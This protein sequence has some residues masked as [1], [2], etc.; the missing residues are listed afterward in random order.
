[1]PE[2]R[3]LPTASLALHPEAAKVP[4][5]P[6][7]QYERFLADVKVRGIREPIELIPHTKIVIEGRTRLR[8]ATDAG[9]AAVPVKD[10]DLADDTP[11]VYMLRAALLRR[12]LTKDQAAML[13]VEL[14]KQFAEEA[15]QR[16]L[17]GAKK[18]GETAGRGRA[19]D[20]ADS[21]VANSPQ[22]NPDPKPAASPKPERAPTSR[23]RAAELAD[24]G[25]RKVSD[26][27]LVTT[28]APEL[29]AKVSAG[30]MKLAAAVKEVKEKEQ[31]KPVTPKEPK[32]AK[33]DNPLAS[34]CQL[35]ELQPCP[36]CGSKNVG[37]TGLE[38]Y[39]YCYDCKA[40]GPTPKDPGRINSTAAWNK[41]AKLK[42]T[43]KPADAPVAATTC[44]KCKATFDS[45]KKKCPSCNWVQPTEAAKPEPSTAAAIS[46]N[47]IT[48]FP[49]DILKKL[50]KAGYAHLG[51]LS[52]AIDKRTDT[53]ERDVRIYATLR[54][55]KGVS[56]K[57]AFAATNAVLGQWMLTHTRKTRA[58]LE[59]LARPPEFYGYEIT[60]STNTRGHEQRTCHY[61]GTE[62]ACKKKALL[63]PN[64]KS[65]VKVQGFT[66]KQYVSAFGHG[67]M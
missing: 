41:R 35:H 34:M 32:P 26:A 60:Y 48:G 63:R 12:H 52:A 67:R 15:K 5:M 28:K 31:P 3:T 4:E 64:A 50:T 57:N 8:A 1:M 19:K 25:E 55:V 44:V 58:E 16:Q 10:A 29:A 59:K 22:A 30:E 66:E 46:F 20:G 24:V 62:A 9:L 13:A 61:V 33:S 7:D 37:L 27:K 40:S 56:A 42:Q 43:E 53:P 2:I 6:A 45:A 65:V 36:F 47:Q 11:M 39:V 18:G 21:P 38:L 49:R 23:A 14:E 17:E 51:Q 54:A